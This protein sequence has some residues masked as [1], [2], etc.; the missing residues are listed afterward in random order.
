MGLGRFLTTVCRA[1]GHV[2]AM[3]I[4]DIRIADALVAGGPNDRVADLQT[5]VP[6]FICPS[7]VGL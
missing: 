1:S 4:N 5:A 6:T 2:R 7:D 3:R